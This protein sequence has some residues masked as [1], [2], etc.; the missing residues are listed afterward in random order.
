MKLPI[1]WLNEYVTFEKSFEEISENLT[2][3]GNEV[4]SIEQIGNIP[5]VIVCEILEIIK[6][7]NANKL[8]ITK[9]YDGLNYYNV[10][11]GAPNI[12]KGQKIF[13]ATIGTKLPDPENN[14]FFD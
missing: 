9:L 11:C 13:L 7:P 5:G 6:H 1:S 2:M 10:V 4:E 3:I 8:Q 14:T 12:K